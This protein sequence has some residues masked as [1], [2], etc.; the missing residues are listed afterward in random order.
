MTAMNIEDTHSEAREVLIRL[1]GAKPAGAKIQS[2]FDSMR[3][4]QQL[5][6]AGIRERHPE[7]STDQVWHAWARQHLGESLYEQAYGNRIRP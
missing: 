4:G 5:A 6:L 3:M 7:L 2:I 1:L